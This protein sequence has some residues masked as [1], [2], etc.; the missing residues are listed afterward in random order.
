MKFTNFSKPMFRV[1][2]KGDQSEIL[3]LIDFVRFIHTERVDERLADHPLGPASETWV[4]WASETYV[5]FSGYGVMLRSGDRFSASEI[6]ETPSGLPWKRDRIDVGEIKRQFARLYPD[7][8]A[9]PAHRPLIDAHPAIYWR[10]AEAAAMEPVL[11]INRMLEIGAGNCVHVAFRHLLNPSMRTVII[12]LP[13]MMFSGYLFL[14]TLGIDVALPHEDREAA[15]TMRLPFQEIDGPFD[16]AFN[17]SSFQEM[18]RSTVDAYIAKARE[19]LR[20]GGWF[21][22]INLTQSRQ[23]EG[24]RAAEYDFAGYETPRIR[25]APLHNALAK[26]RTLISVLARRP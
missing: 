13:Q 8:A 9:P 21:H 5:G 6:E 1:A 4:P 25:H 3:P 11:S 10:V 26:P 18:R 2:F 24:N 7:Y 19:L 12:D 23:I 15:V 22:H 20:P 16:F 14:R 17:K